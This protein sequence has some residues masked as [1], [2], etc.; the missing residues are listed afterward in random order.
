MAVPNFNPNFNR[1]LKF[2]PNINANLDEEKNLFPSRTNFHY[3]RTYSKF[4]TNKERKESFF[5]SNHVSLNITN[6]QKRLEPK[7]EDK[8][9]SPSYVTNDDY[10]DKIIYSHL[11]DMRKW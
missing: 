6:N 5:H 2:L 3:K 1:A 7:D 11:I 4:L 8:F 9:S 10:E